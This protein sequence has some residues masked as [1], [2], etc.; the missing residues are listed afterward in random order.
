M[1]NDKVLAMLKE[2]GLPLAYD[3]FPEGKAPKPPFLVYRYPSSENFAADNICYA[4]FQNLDVE[5]Y[6]EKKASELEARLEALLTAHECFCEKSEVY[7]AS[8]KLYELLYQM[9]V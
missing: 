6:T 8:E 2:A 7:I 9:T 5:L 1:T 4:S 3:H